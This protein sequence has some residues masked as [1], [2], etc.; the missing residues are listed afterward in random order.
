[1]PSGNQGEV[2]VQGERALVVDLDGTLVRSDILVESAF[3]YLATNP[4]R[5]LNLF[6]LLTRGKAALKAGI[7]AETPIDPTLL[8]YNVSVLTLI[9]DARRAGCQVYIAS[10]GN[11]RYVSAV[12]AHIRADGW[13]ASDDVLDLSSDAKAKRLVGAFGDRGF[14]YV[15][16]REQA[17]KRLIGSLFFCCGGI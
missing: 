14:D 4:F 16:V 5:L 15:V 12:A 1:M 2:D 11:E 7:A 13:F 8:P 6:T 9:E 3:A 17:S 10:A